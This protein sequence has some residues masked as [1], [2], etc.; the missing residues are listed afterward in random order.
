MKRQALA[1]L[2]LTAVVSFLLGLV[3]AGP[4]SDSAQPPFRPVATPFSPGSPTGNPAPTGSQSTVLVGAVDFSGV[5]KPTPAAIF[6]RLALA[7]SG[8]GRLTLILRSDVSESRRHGY[9]ATKPTTAAARGPG[10]RLKRTIFCRLTPLR[11]IRS[12]TP[13]KLLK[14]TGHRHLRRGDRIMARPSK[15]PGHNSVKQG[16]WR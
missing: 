14:D 13:S 8:A 9:Y 4:R 1:L 3:A 12:S 2:A 16:E 15:A 11:A 6:L 7:A 10:L 5:A